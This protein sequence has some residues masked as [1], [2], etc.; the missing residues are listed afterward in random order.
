MRC[1]IVWGVIILI[2]GVFQFVLLKVTS[3]MIYS[4]SV[5]YPRWYGTALIII[6]GIVL[7]VLIILGGVSNR[8]SFRSVRIPEGKNNSKPEENEVDAKSAETE[9]SS[10]EESPE[11]EHSSSRKNGGR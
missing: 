10:L 5:Y 11:T 4:T 8:V 2:L 7:P 6:C 1:I 9:N 3:G